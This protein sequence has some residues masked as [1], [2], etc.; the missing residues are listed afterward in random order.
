VLRDA[1]LVVTGE[2]TTADLVIEELNER[3]VPVVRFDL[4]D[5][6]H[7]VAATARYGGR[8]FA[9][10]LRTDSRQADLSAVR[11]VYYRR[12]T[13]PEFVGLSPQEAR[14]SKDQARFGLSGVLAALPDCRQ[15]NHP[16][17]QMAAEYKPAQLAAAVEL[18]FEVPATIV[19]N[20]HEDARLFV[21][22]QGI[23]VYKPLWSTDFE[24]NGEARTI[25][26]RAV[27]A[28][29][30]DESVSAT[31]HLFQARVDKAADVRV[32]VVG[33]KVFCV[34]IESSLTDW[35][36]NYELV[37]GYSVIDPPAGLCE[38][39]ARYLR[40]FGLAYGCFDFG[41]DALDGTWWWYECN[42]AG[43]WGWIEAETGLP[44]ARAFADLL[45]G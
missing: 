15:V 41:I 17:L 10:A 2:D 18:G 44:I 9:G 11:A 39:L 23:A 14:F 33:D 40:R 37:D 1:V 12:P 21:E 35:R 29:E 43:E 22:E 8:A 24:E 32:T 6:P 38:L 19:T 36:E 4:A 26:V 42:P 28:D 25:W 31:A 3:T 34:R 7:S 16:R 13:S 20:R 27:A 45:A 5:F 30:L